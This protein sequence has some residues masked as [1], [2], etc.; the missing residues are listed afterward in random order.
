M[1]DRLARL[2]RSNGN[3]G[4]QS[5]ADSATLLDSD[6]FL[7]ATAELAPQLGRDVDDVRAEAATY[8]R[9]MSA[10]HV[11][12][13]VRAWEA[14]SAW[15][16]RGFQV[17]INDDDLAKL[18][19]LDR[20]HALIFLISHRS[21]LD[22][23]S[24]PPRLARGGISPT[25]GL[26][27]ANLNFFPLG[28]LARRNGFIPVRRA[29]GDVPV[30]RLA[31]RALVG[32][33]VA[34]GRNLVWSIEGGRT[35]T[36]KLRPPRYG[37]LRYVTDAVESVQSEQTL[38]VPVS[39]LFDQLPL[40]E[41]K[42]MAAESRGLPKKPENARWL[43]SYARGLRHRLGRIYINFGTPVPLYER[44]VALR[45]EGLS[46]RQIVERIALDICH[47]LNQTTPV[48]ATAA[49]CVAM[50]G[51]DRALTLDEV[52]ATVAPLARYLRA[53]GW[54]VA[55]GADLTDR[56][57][58]SQT[59]HDLVGSGVL[60]SYSEGPTTVW[61]IGEDQH[62]IVAVYRNSAIHVLVM[63]AIAELALLAIVRTPGA[64]KRTGWEKA[65][66]IRELLKF[67]FFFAGR[68]EFAD[69][70]WNEFSIMTGRS[71]DPS[72]PLDTEEAARSLRES[73]LLVA[74]LVV[75]PFV[76]AY[77]VVSEE[78]LNL[79][80][81]REVDEQTLLR[82]CLRLGRQWSLQH[83]ITEESVSGEMFSTAVKMARHRGLLDAGAPD[84]VERREALV[85]ELDDLQ[86]SIGELAQMR[87]YFATG[88][89]GVTQ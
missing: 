52:C 49:V 71:H 75:R 3:A 35:R 61:G 57:T 25:F 37:L 18:R 83:R 46:D 17:V 53:R 24:F 80:A 70:L 63:R 23:F 39:I 31:L 72:A 15:M 45:A 21:Y 65:L 11:P 40:H 14:W 50:L 26:G 42:L 48:T 36:G 85:S 55:G 32:H 77:R 54:P 1:P 73:D 84:V 38:A 16:V 9:E 59:L 6:G 74:H 13:V 69:E 88:L 29:T 2:L 8:V 4:T 41:V 20:D 79:G 10:T 22:Q 81:G 33:M 66:A 28:T 68:D 19:E 56:A 60:T 7:T 67:D 89:R 47:R 62:L 51:E 44:M 30:Y 34:S 87:R 64:T 5:A 82:R 43:L 58:V 27:G 78:L 86:R 76:D 12:P